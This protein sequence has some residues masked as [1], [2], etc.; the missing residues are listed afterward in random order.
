MWGYLLDACETAEAFPGRLCNSHQALGVAGGALGKDN[1]LGFNL[2]L[3]FWV[4][5]L[6]GA[7][8]EG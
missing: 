3:G 1:Y 2:G 6:G 4:W 8:R 7:F 5:G